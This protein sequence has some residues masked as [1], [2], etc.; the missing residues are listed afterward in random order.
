VCAE[1]T[2]RAGD[3]VDLGGRG[4]SNGM[5]DTV[6]CGRVECCSIC[7]LLSIRTLTSLFFVFTTLCIQSAPRPYWLEPSDV[8]VDA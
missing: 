8:V 7:I 3:G 5:V 4:R 1:G 6:V 2:E